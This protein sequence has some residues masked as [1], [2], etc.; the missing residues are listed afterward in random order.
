MATGATELWIDGVQ[1]ATGTYDGT[2]VVGSISGSIYPY[3]EMS[4]F[5][6]GDFA[7][8][9]LAI[10]KGINLSSPTKR[11]TFVADLY[12]GGTGL[13]YSGGTWA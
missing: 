5:T 11:S 4:C 3:L 8:D 6:T 7:I 1:N 2:L 10:W 12:K 13:F 9:E